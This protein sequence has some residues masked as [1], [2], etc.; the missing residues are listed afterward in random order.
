MRE[1]VVAAL[2]FFLLDRGTKH[3]VKSRTAEEGSCPGPFVACVI[4]AKASY[5]KFSNRLLLLSLWLL[6]C[7]CA[8]LLHRWEI[9]F[10]S[11]LELWGLG[12]AL[13]GSAGN[14]WDILWHN[15]VIDFIDLGWWPVFNLADVAIV[16]G[17]AAA[18]LA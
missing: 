17:L 4:H 14:L 11:H 3:L 1:A 18:F 6:A 8:L 12:A 10:H 7:F 5:A 15:G 2:I 9:H 13:G 16:V